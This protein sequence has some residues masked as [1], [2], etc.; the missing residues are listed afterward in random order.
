MHA[1]SFCVGAGSSQLPCVGKHIHCLSS[2]QT[3][4]FKNNKRQA[5]VPYGYEYLGNS[6]RLVI[7]PL[8]DRCDARDGWLRRTLIFRLPGLPLFHPSSTQQPT[9]N[10]TQPNAN[11]QNNSTPPPRCYMTL[12]SALHLNLGGAPA[13]PAGTGKTETTKDLAKALAKQCVVFNCSDGLDYIAMVGG[14]DCGNVVS[15]VSVVDWGEGVVSLL[16]VW[17]AQPL[18]YSCI[19]FSSV[20]A[21]ISP[22]QILQGP[23]QQRR[24]GVLRRVQPHRP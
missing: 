9:D 16:A 20:W 8:T 17:L 11:N 23:G 3:Q 12:M 1:P 5:S 10:P 15:V 4:S 2:S 24:L 7:T 6:P 18:R 22:G 21:P 13:G 19:V 14:P